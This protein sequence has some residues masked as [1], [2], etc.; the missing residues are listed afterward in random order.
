M[1][2]IVIFLGNEL[3]FELPIYDINSHWQK[4][5]LPIDI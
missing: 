4:K 1:L 3:F 5:S 2:N